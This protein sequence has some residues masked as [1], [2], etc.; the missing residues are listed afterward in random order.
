MPP[1]TIYPI[2]A[3]TDNYI[4]AIVDK[5]SQSAIL[6]DVGEAKPALQFLSDNGLTLQEIWLTH[7]HHDHI[8]GV[9]EICQHFPNIEVKVHA[10][11]AKLLDINQQKLVKD[12]DE[13]T[14]FGYSVKVWQVAGHTD[15]HLAYLLDIDGQMHVFCGDTLF[16]AG[17]GRV[18][19]GTIEQ[20]FAS[21]QRLNTLDD[22]AIFYPAH[23]Y[24]LSN[25][26]FAQHIE[27]NH[28]PIQQA[29][30]QDRVKRQ[31]NLPTLPTTLAE[32]RNINPFI[33]AL[34][35]N[36][37]MVKTLEEQQP[38]LIFSKLRTLKNNF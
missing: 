2:S 1:I 6:V 26:A 34:Q 22:T 20:L 9:D 15:N 13:F 38:L 14:T 3:F 31:Q 37:T 27:P 11:V 5:N 17:C 35:P 21:F 32:E 30:E 8:G 36:D 18:F 24:T 33:R 12:N 25:L 23:E 16:R 19:T 4:W 29:I 28:L 10:E 7:H